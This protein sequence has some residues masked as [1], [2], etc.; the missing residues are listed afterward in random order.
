ML[1]RPA[2]H[3]G[4]WYSGDSTRLKQQIS[5]FF[6]KTGQNPINGARILLGPH[7]GYTYLGPRLAE[8]FSVWD[9][10]KTKRIF[11]L[12]PSHHVYFRNKVLVS[13]YSGYDTPLGVLPVDKEVC[14]ELCT[15]APSVFGYMSEEVD[16]EEHLFEMH[17]PFIAYRSQEDGI[18]VKIVP[19]MIL[20]LNSEVRDHVV[21]YL[22]PYVKDESNSFVVLSDFCHW[23]RRFGYTKYVPNEDWT[24][25]TEYSAIRRGKTPIYKSI[26]ILDKAAMEVASLGLSEEWDEYIAVTGNTVCG[27]KPLGVILRLLEFCGI[28]TSWEWIGYSQSSRVMEG[29]DLSVSYASGY[30]R[31]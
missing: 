1:I 16:D 20:G 5:G 23:G 22:A 13:K 30:M 9:T 14:K 24:E 18:D 28:S 31:I 25:L 3:G 27:Q 2:T 12:G 4:T 15:V 29:S 17:A 11:I 10:G 19:I 8:T 7:A 21:R 26:E 6:K